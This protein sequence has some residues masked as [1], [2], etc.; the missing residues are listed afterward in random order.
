M[1]GAALRSTLLRAWMAAWLVGQVGGTSPSA[2]SLAVSTNPTNSLL[3]T[4]RKLPQD[5]DWP[6]AQD[7]AQ[8]N[9]TVGGRLIATVPVAQVCHDPAYNATACAW[10]KE[11]WLTVEAH[12]Y[13]PAEILNPYFQGQ[14]CEPFTPK[15]KPCTL[16]NY[17]VYSINVTGVSDIQ[18]GL[19]FATRH[20]VR[21]TIKNTGHD[22]LGKS[23]GR[24]ALSLWTHNLKGLEFIDDYA[25]DSLYTGSAV[26]IGAGIMFKDV[27]PVA[28][29]RGKRVVS[30]TCGT[31]GAAGGYTAGGGHGSLT[32][33]YGMAADSVLEWE[34]VTAAGEHLTVTPKQ[35]ADLYWALSG[36][37]AGTF[38]VIVSMTTRTY[39][40]GPMQGA[41]FTVSNSNTTA[42]WNTV[43]L[44]H[45]SLAPVVDTGAT[46]TYFILGTEL[47]VFAAVIPGSDPALVTSTLAPI[48]RSLAQAGVAVNI[49]SSSFSSYYALYE[50]YFV[51][52][53][54][55]TDVGQI[56]G[57]RIIPRELLEP[58][59]PSLSKISAALQGFTEAGFYIACAALNANSS[60]QAP[61]TSNA[62]FPVWRSALLTCIMVQ[63]WDYSI[64]WDENLERQASLTNIYMP[65]LEAVTP[66]G[67]AYLNEAN[68]QDPNWQE[69]FYGDNYPRLG[70]VK[71]RYDP[72]ELFYARTAVGS[73]KWKENGDGRL[74]RV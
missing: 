20:D 18:A 3:S 63:T 71:Q 21:L 74:C 55:S 4:C 51:P 1:L 57:G 41:G 68:F 17:A 7:W 5:A 16:G 72:N 37:G 52:T 69:V 34:V 23:T 28:A 24:G 59:S 49:S 26:R 50:S 19:A 46:L 65:Q 64:P 2:S 29:A 45:S 12:V 60:R 48:V 44:F 70:V 15:G 31:V 32:S 33:L 27:L 47:I 67:G 40:D 6:S 36:G 53:A 10:F 22:L 61:F 73:E 14:Y 54:E 66:G 13:Y 58:A 38:A 25:G 56:T 43:D 42:F 8:L 39:D 30:G 11:N 9:Q 62:V 35:H